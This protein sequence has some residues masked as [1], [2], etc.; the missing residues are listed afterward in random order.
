MNAVIL[1]HQRFGRLIVVQRTR[2]RRGQAVWKCL[3]DCGG[4]KETV[5]Y[6][7]R[8]GLTQSCGCIQKERASKAR[9]IHGESYKSKEYSIWSGM[10]TRCYNS[11]DNSYKNYGAR[12]ITVCER[13]LHSFHN[14]LFDMGRCPIGCSLER[15]D[16]D[17]CYLLENCIWA[18]KIVQANNTRANRFLS[19]DGFRMTLAQWARFSGL[20]YYTLH[21]RLKRGWSIDAAIKTPRRMEAA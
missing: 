3:C 1:L 5:A 13:W 19:C 6:N 15:K 21:Y 20:P 8:A 4:T 12:G 10:K 16:N 14:F 2:T 18:P 11:A 17:K 9:K 7:L